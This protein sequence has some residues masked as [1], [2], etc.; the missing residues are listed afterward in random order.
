[1]APHARQKELQQAALQSVD[2]LGPISTFMTLIKGFLNSAI[3]F[4]PKIFVNGGWGFTAFALVFINILTNISAKLLMESRVRVNAK[5]YADLGFLAYGKLG[6]FAVEIALFFCQTSFVTA[7]IYFIT[8][9]IHQILLHQFDY[10]ISPEAVALPLY[11]VMGILCLV[12]RIEVFA[13][14]HLLADIIIILTCIVVTYH[15]VIKLRADGSRLSTVDFVDEVTFA[16]SIG[17]FVYVYE[18]I[19]VLMPVEDV[20]RDKSQYRLIM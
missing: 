5:S 16:D 8:Q 6:R 19:G 2:L 9:N 3:L 12:R 17:F 14:T 10:N 4:A 11:F 18:G 15:A 13:W 20:T 1:M 7:Y